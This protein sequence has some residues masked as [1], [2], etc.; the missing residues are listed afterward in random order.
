MLKI[1][2][3]SGEIDSKCIY[4]KEDWVNIDIRYKEGAEGW[5]AAKFL[6]FDIFKP[7]W[8]IEND[9]ADCLYA[10][11]ILEHVNYKVL[12]LVLKECHRILKKD[13]PMRIICPDPRIFIENWKMD[14]SQFLR[15]CYGQAN[16]DKYDYDKNRNM[17]FSD[18]FFEGSYAH[19]LCPSIDLIMIFLIKAGFKYINEMNYM[20]TAYPEF[21]GSQD[22]NDKHGESVDNRP[23]MSYYIEAVK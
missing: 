19:V 21:F 6:C 17:G 8:P 15:D 22:P 11:H 12:L 3:G 2:L 7:G 10:S 18:M 14:N 20:N 4:A 9:S 1:N 23:G 16:Y 5:C 13:A